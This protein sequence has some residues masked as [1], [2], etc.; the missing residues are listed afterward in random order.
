MRLSP[1]VKRSDALD[2]TGSSAAEPAGG[3]ELLGC[4]E[5]VGAALGDGGVR[6]NRG[7]RLARR[8][9][10]GVLGLVLAVVAGPGLPAGQRPV[11]HEAETHFADPFAIAWFTLTGVDEPASGYERPPPMASERPYCIG[12]GRLDWADGERSPSVAHCVATDVV[13]QLDPIDLVVMR[14]SIAGDSTWSLLLFGE[15]VEAVMVE[16]DGTDLAAD[17]VF[18]AGRFVA[19]LVPNEHRRLHLAWTTESGHRPHCS[20]SPDT[21]AGRVCA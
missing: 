19:L 4:I 2:P 18:R 20:L 11:V 21:G 3:I 9:G 13:A 6:S 10:L 1:L 15:N 7:R 17:R 14:E 12:F 16:V 5:P 8:L